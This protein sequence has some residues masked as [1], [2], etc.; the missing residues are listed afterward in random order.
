MLQK[1]I[2]LWKSFNNNFIDNLV[3]IKIKN[4]KEKYS[5]IMS[6]EQLIYKWIDESKKKEYI[7]II[8]KKNTLLNWKYE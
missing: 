8:N 3:E 5:C 1:T 2:D 4:E 7:S 6:N